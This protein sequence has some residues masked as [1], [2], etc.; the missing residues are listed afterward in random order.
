MSTNFRIPEFEIDYLREKFQTI[1]EGYAEFLKTETTRQIPNETLS[2][3]LRTAMR[4]ALQDK[5]LHELFLEYGSFSKWELDWFRE[6]LFEYVNILQMY[7]I[8]D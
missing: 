7:P 4:K 3:Y 5:D 1:L 2:T 6:C 8:D